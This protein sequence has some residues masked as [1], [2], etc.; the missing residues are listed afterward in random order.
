MRKIP[1]KCKNKLNTNT[2]NM[3]IIHQRTHTNQKTPPPAQ[4]QNIS[5]NQS[6]RIPKK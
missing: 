3:K 6:N 4:N 5:C 1:K 2:Q